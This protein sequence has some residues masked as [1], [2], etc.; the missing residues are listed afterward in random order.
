MGLKNRVLILASKYRDLL[1]YIVAQAKLESANFTSKVYRVDNN[2]FGM[3]VGSSG[4]PGLLS[5][6]GDYYRH[7]END[8]ES[9]V[10]L[11]EWLDKKS[12]PVSV[13]SPDEYAIELR[14]R[15]Y[16]TAPLEVYQKNLKY[17]LNL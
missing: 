8:T 1:P 17:W 16:F 5:P 11:L 14:K 3:K 2:M 12:F 7:Y 13:V 9:L 6:E 10:A 15:N 4:K